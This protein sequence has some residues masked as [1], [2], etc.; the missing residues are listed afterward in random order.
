MK[1]GVLLASLMLLTQ[2][3]VAAV[4]CSTIDSATR[5]EH[6]GTFTNI[7]Q[8]GEHAYGYAIDL[9]R[10]GDCLFGLFESAEGLAG[11]TPAGE[12]TNVRYDARTNALS[13]ISKLTTGMT[14]VEGSTAWI[15]SQDLFTFSGHVGQR[16]IT[17]TLR[18]SDALRPRAKTI[19]S[20][21]VLPVARREPSMIDARTYG[22]WQAMVAPIL[23]F[24]GPKW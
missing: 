7:R 22:E 8:S 15:P 2:P 10:A 9:W 3:S 14:T 24:R 21:I 12:L 1:R 13:F 18:R 16:G 6:I 11:D 19:E 17:G 20:A 23:R 4:D 5:V